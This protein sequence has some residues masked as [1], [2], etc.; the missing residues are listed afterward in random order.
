MANSQYKRVNRKRVCLICGKPDW[1]SYT[2]DEKISFCARVA[3]CADRVSRH[4]WGVF[5]HQKSL[6]N[7]N[8]ISFPFES[9]LKKP[10][11]ELAPLEIRDFAYR[12][13]IEL[14]PATNYKEIIDGPKGL[15]TRKILDFENYGSLP[16]SRSERHDLAKTV[17]TFINR[18]FPDYVRKRKSSLAGLPGFWLDEREK[19]QLWLDKDYLY[20]LMLIPYRNPNGLVQACQIRYMCRTSRNEPRYVWLS[21]PEKSGGVSCGC[22][23]HYAGRFSNL[24][25]SRKPILATEGALKAETAQTFKPEFNVVAISGVASSHPEL[26]KVARFLPLIVAFDND[27]FQNRQVLRQLARLFQARFSDSKKYNYNS[28]LSILIWCSAVKGVD[29]ALL[30]NKTITQITFSEWLQSLDEQL[31]YEVLQQVC[32]PVC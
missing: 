18:E 22:P 16:P 7:P 6:I 1:C 20:P 26:I 31:R 32:Y 9:R 15:R 12:K 4:G 25:S 14:A 3:N 19:A 8:A 30:Y 2:P 23:L 11:A 28:S 24:S 5:Y 29:D 21:T 10:S 13:L 27:Y 17:R